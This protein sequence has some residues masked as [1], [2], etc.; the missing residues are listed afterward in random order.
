MRR[1]DEAYDTRALDSIDEAIYN[2]Q[3]T[4]LYNRRIS[5]LTSGMF[6]PARLGNEV[7][8]RSRCIASTAPRRF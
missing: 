1:L 7:W 5:L 3:I 2:S 4:S 6:G 8:R